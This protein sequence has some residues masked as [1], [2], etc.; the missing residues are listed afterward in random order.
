M[1]VKLQRRAQ[2]ALSMPELCSFIFASTDLSLVVSTLPQIT[3]SESHLVE[4]FKLCILARQQN[5]RPRRK[6]EA[7]INPQRWFEDYP[8]ATFM[9]IVLL[10]GFFL[11]ARRGFE[12]IT[13]RAI[14]DED[15]RLLDVLRSIFESRRQSYSLKVLE[16]PSVALPPFDDHR[17][18]REFPTKIRHVNLHSGN[19]VYFA[20]CRFI[21]RL[22]RLRNFDTHLALGNKILLPPGLKFLNICEWLRFHDHEPLGHALPVTAYVQVYALGQAVEKKC[23]A[24]ALYWSTRL[25]KHLNYPRTHSAAWQGLCEEINNLASTPV[26]RTWHRGSFGELV[27]AARR[28]QRLP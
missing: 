27:V 6:A 2:S 17:D 22:R 7:K 20:P 12:I 9:R 25:L 11:V 4:A 19:A 5:L 10:P 26:G 24:W 14:R 3:A 16:W 18:K 21:R 1:L 23:I 8:T 13:R 15:P 28:I